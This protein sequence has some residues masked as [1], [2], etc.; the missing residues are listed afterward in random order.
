MYNTI[1]HNNESIDVDS[2]KNGV[3]LYGGSP[4]PQTAT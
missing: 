2:Y 4:S 1:H 3:K